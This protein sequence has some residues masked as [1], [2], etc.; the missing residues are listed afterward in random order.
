MAPA[1]S[2]LC[3]CLPAPA[4][5][6]L[7]PGWFPDKFI[8]VLTESDQRSLL[9][10][11]RAADSPWGSV[12]KRLQRRW[13]RFIEGPASTHTSTEL[14]WEKTCCIGDS[15]NCRE[16]LQEFKEARR[17]EKTQ[18]PAFAECLLCAGLPMKP[19]QSL[20]QGIF[21]T[22]GACSSH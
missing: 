17:K 4:P 18:Q 13:T 1:P 14:L 21:R 7:P 5:L 10:E 12:D 19:F 9:E 6:H 8:A 11:S 16:V 20:F 3:A 15:G 2:P 22:R